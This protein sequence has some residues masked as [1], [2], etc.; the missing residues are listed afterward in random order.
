[1]LCH[2]LCTFN[3]LHTALQIKNFT[4]SAS[5]IK[6]SICNLYENTENKGLLYVKEAITCYYQID[7]FIVSK[8]EWNTK[9]D[10]WSVHH[11]TFRYGIQF[12]Y[13]SSQGT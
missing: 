12:M 1:M 3:P 7:T 9:E 4:K 2:Q 11:Y 5:F 6:K 8:D 13:M 10:S